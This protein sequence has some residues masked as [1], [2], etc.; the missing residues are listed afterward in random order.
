MSEFPWTWTGPGCTGIIAYDDDT[1][2]VYHARNLDFGP[3]HIFHPLLYIARYQKN[4]K[5]ILRAQHIAGYVFPLTAMRPRAF[6]YETNTRF[7]SHKGQDVEM[8]HRLVQRVPRRDLAGWQIRQALVQ[9]ETYAA[10]TS[11]I[12]DAR[13]V[14]PMYNIISGVNKG[15]IFAHGIDGTS[16]EYALE[17][18]KPNYEQQGRYIIATNFDF[19]D[20]DITEDFDVTG[21]LGYRRRVQASRI[22]NAS[23][24]LT[25]GVLFDTINHKHV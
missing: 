10:F 21:G 19:W 24:V 4:G 22:L 1:D 12:R 25:P 15:V 2:S 20:H 5:D 14:A 8:L 7:C 17:K 6:S 18:D 23:R 3:P 13:F 16:F 9:S 11:T